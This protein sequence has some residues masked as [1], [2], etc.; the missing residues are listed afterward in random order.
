VYEQYDHISLYA[1]LWSWGPLARGLFDS[2]V[3]PAVM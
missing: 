2:V 1:W 3:A